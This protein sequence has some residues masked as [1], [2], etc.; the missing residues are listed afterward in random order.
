MFREFCNKRLFNLN[1]F[2]T[3]W[4]NINKVLYELDYLREN[5]PASSNK[6]KRIEDYY[7]KRLSEG[8]Q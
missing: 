2:K 6:I 3:P 1:E 8:F 5:Y 7:D 4:T